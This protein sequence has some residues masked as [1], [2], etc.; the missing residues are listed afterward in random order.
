MDDITCILTLLDIMG[1][2]RHI[3]KL[4]EANTYL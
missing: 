4:M 1:L 2:A 3:F